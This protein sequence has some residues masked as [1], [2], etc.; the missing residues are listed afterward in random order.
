MEYAHMKYVH[1]TSD[2]SSPTTSHNPSISHWSILATFKNPPCK[3]CPTHFSFLLCNRAV[4]TFYLQAADNDPSQAEYWPFARG[5]KSS[6]LIRITGILRVIYIVLNCL[7]ARVNWTPLNNTPQV[8]AE[9][10]VSS[11]PRRYP[12]VWYF[13]IMIIFV[14]SQSLNENNNEAVNKRV[15]FIFQMS[16]CYFSESS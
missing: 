7:G 14:S 4:A 5:Y 15:K 3:A 10:C 12:S 9:H 8:S 11:E 2:F 6:F 13:E 16:S 1:C